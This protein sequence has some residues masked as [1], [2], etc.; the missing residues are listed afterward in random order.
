MSALTTGPSYA[1][2]LANLLGRHE[3][4]ITRRLRTLER[5]D[6]VESRWS[7]HDGKN[8]KLYTLKT[9]RF[10]VL[11][12]A[13]GYRMK[14]ATS[15]PSSRPSPD[16]GH[17]PG[18]QPLFGRDEELAALAEPG[19]RFIIVVGLPGIGKTS[20]VAEFAHQ[21]GADRVLWHGLTPFDT[22]QRLLEVAARWVAPVDSPLVRM[23]EGPGLDL[24][25]ALEKVT[26]RLARRRVL[27]VLDDYQK[28]RDEGINEVVRRWQRDLRYGKLIV[29]SRT[30]PPIDLDPRSQILALSGLRPEASRALLRS[31]GL[32]VSPGELQRLQRDYGGHPLTLILYGRQSAGDPESA[33]RVL[34]DLGRKAVD[35]LDETS[36]T[37]LLALAAV[38]RPQELAALRLLTD[39]PDPSLCLIPLE[40]RALVRSM[41]RGYAVHEVLREALA[42][43]VDDRRELHQRAMT[44]YL[45]SNEAEDILEALYHAV[46]ADDL[47]VAAGILEADLLQERHRMIDRGYL[48]PYLE[49]LD[50][51]PVARLGTRH[52]ALVHYG[53]ARILAAMAKQ[54]AA[55]QEFR[56][57]EDLAESSG[58]PRLLGIVLREFGSVLNSAGRRDEAERA[59]RRFL[60]I[61]ETEEWTSQKADALWRLHTVY[62]RQDATPRAREFYDLALR[63]AKSI[64]DE[65][66]VLEIT[67]FCSMSWPQDRRRVMPTLRRRAALYRKLGR[68]V[69]VAQVHAYLGEIAC[70]LARWTGSRGRKYAQEALGYLDR[71]VTAFET[72]GD[73]RQAANARSWRALALFLTDKTEDAESEAKVVL[74]M[75]RD[76]G[77]DHSAILGNEV[78]AYVSRSQGNLE[79]ARRAADSAVRM[80]QRL[81]CRC[82]GVV[83]VERALVEEALGHLSESRR[84]L[85][86]A[87]EEAIRRGTP[88]EAS[89]A[90]RV[91]RQRGL[92]FT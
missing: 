61:V 76:L 70:R 77:P 33:R 71:A 5:A 38:R 3:T 90:R 37:L 52:R 54:S 87:V 40:R 15:A 91:A 62:H 85:R 27:I 83:Q 11:L 59:F 53:R 31:R 72:L 30:R 57:A 73:A 42:P 13:Q 56:L 51:I 17:L 75:Q 79:A 35:A 78:L 36:R 6:L 44:M 48:H 34:E 67:T 12:E 4:Q 20:L 82:K 28:V 80:A 74:T 16:L 8:V 18:R 43:I 64:G 7:R 24:A 55:I 86:E 63:E 92:R 69:Q 23:F 81:D 41:S 39:I 47:A 60:A 65:E 10:E 89:Y 50:E 1:R 14:P 84:M 26:S 32:R 9:R 25:A 46:R 29:I 58:E 45:K 88:D 2:L 68:P 66:L 21:Y 49:V 19:M 22:S